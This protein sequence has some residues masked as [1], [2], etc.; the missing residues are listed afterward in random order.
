MIVLLLLF[1]FGFLLFLLLPWFPWLEFPKQCWIKMAR[2]VFVSIQK[3]F[4]NSFVSCFLVGALNQLKCK[5]ISC[6]FSVCASILFPRFLII[7]TSIILNSFSCKVAIS[8][9]VSCS[10]QFLCNVFLYLFLS[11]DF[12]C[13]W[14]LLST[15]CR[16]VVPIA[17]VLCTLVGEVSPGT[18][19]G[20]QP[21]G[22]WS[23]VLFL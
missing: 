16:I 23:W 1:Q 17:S 13:F 21:S 14:S 4:W 10:C 8:S 22:V 15:G 9:S 19:I 2:V 11:F 20:C 5:V 18:W 7:F 6:I 12:L 3:L